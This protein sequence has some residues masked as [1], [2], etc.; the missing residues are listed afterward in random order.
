MNARAA[1]DHSVTITGLRV[2]FENCLHPANINY[3]DNET[4]AAA[5]LFFSNLEALERDY[6]DMLRIG[7]G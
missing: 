6:Q 5:L 3:P 2:F 7:E 1:E 4:G